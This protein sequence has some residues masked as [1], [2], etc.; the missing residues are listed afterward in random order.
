[1]QGINKMIEKGNQIYL[2]IQLWGANPLHGVREVQ[3]FQCELFQ[4]YL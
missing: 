4:K 1:M 2:E 3:L